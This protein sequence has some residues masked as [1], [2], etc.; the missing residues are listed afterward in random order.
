MID[1]RIPFPLGVAYYVTGL[2]HYRVGQ[3]E[4][5]ATQFEHALEEQS[6]QARSITFPALAM[7]YHRGGN[8]DQARRAFESSEKAIDAWTREML[9]ASVGRTPMPWFDW[10]EMRLLHREA[11]ILLT[12]YAPAED[13]R[14]RTIEERALAAIQGGESATPP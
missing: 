9:Q 10:I 3:F 13:S 12:G 11:A 5:A 2:A 7:A 6:W 8:A 4:N 1:G 14:L